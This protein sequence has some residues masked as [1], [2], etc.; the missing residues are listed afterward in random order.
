MVC[1]AR[2]ILSSESKYCILVRWRKSWVRFS[3]WSSFLISF[4]FPS[5]GLSPISEINHCPI[6]RGAYFRCAVHAEFS[7][8]KTFAV[9]GSVCSGHWENHFTKSATRVWFF[10]VQDSEFQL[11]GDCGRWWLNNLLHIRLCK[12]LEK[13]HKRWDVTKQESHLLSARICVHSSATGVV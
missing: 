1:S 4:S 10:S 11:N 5:S 2:S 13:S 8:W 3:I 12:R 9:T 6:N 7:K